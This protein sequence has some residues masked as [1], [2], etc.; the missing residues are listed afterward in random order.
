[1]GKYGDF[2]AE[3]SKF[4]TINYGEKHSVIWTGNG[5]RTKLNFAGKTTEGFEFE[6]VTPNG[7]KTWFTGNG[8]IIKQFDDYK[9]GEELIISRKNKGETPMWSVTKRD[10]VPF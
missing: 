6:F 3:K 10:S 7:N 8:S 1:M 9:E 5:I 4:L 2:A